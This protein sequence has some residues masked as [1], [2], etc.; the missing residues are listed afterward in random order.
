MR[1]VAGSGTDHPPTRHHRHVPVIGCAAGLDGAHVSERRE[2]VHRLRDQRSQRVPWQLDHLHG[3]VRIVGAGP[4]H[5]RFGGPG[6]AGQQLTRRNGARG[7]GGEFLGFEQQHGEPRRCG[8]GVVGVSFGAAFPR[9][10][11]AGEHHVGEA[12]GEVTRA[13]ARREHRVDL[14]GREGESRPAD[15]EVHRAFGRE[16][17]GL[18]AVVEGL[19]DGDAVVAIGDGGTMLVPEVHH[20]TGAQ[21]RGQ[22]TGRF[23]VRQPA[24]SLRC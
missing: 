2:V 8:G 6:D 23:D 10:G 17:V 15:A 21:R 1:L 18:G 24:C 13:G 16:L 19:G 7:D 20:V 22:S 12:V 9:E 5:Q 4:F 14:A 11:G 3:L